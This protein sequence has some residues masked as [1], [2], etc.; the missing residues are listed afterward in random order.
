MWYNRD[1]RNDFL[2]NW[3]YEGVVLE[4]HFRLREF[5]D[6]DGLVVIDPGLVQS[7]ELLRRDLS[8][9]YSKDVQIVITSGT[10]TEADNEK[11]AERL[12]WCENGGQVAR[13]SKHL[14]KYGGIAVDM[15][16]RYR[17][18][19]I[20]AVVPQ[21]TLGSACLVHFA[22]VK[23]DYPDGHVHADNRSW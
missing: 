9:F 16:A 18:G 20:W 10:R 14:P 19:A 8:R 12:G 1:M 22:Y 7:L 13:D 11:L 21:T 23:A 5:E 6:E 4:S 17:E 15:Y 2:L 3:E